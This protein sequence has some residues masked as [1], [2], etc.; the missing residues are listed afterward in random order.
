MFDWLI[1]NKKNKELQ[2]AYEEAE[3]IAMV[4]A[5]KKFSILSK[6]FINY[7]IGKAFFI[8][9]PIIFFTF[10]WISLRT[11]VFSVSVLYLLF[12]LIFLTT[13]SE[14]YLEFFSVVRSHGCHPMAIL[15]GYIYRKVHDKTMP[16]VVGEYSKFKVRV[17]YFLSRRDRTRDMNEFVHKVAE[18]TARRVAQRVAWRVLGDGIRMGIALGAYLIIFRLLV[19][20]KLISPDFPKIH[21][22]KQVVLP[23]AVSVDTLASSHL[24]S[25]LLAY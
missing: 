17:I 4:E 1:N 15:R 16:E 8:C 7:Q 20:P 24:T 21:M 3:T 10:G 2:K 25:M 13:I 22:V 18:E 6:D 12:A 23:L 11:T 19:Y 5:D 14:Y 9:A